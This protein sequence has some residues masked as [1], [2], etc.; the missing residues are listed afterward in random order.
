MGP[1]RA[2]L[3]VAKVPN[4]DGIH[5]PFK[6]D[7]KTANE[8]IKNYF[9]DGVNDHAYAMANGNHL[10]SNKRFGQAGSRVPKYRNC[11]RI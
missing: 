5:L 1:L 9:V 10:I 8:R 7:V 11:T 2:Q 4:V 3:P 6:I